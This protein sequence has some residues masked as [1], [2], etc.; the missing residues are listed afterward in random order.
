[1]TDR[2]MMVI[3]NNSLS[4]PRIVKR[5]VQT[6]IAMAIT[7][8]VVL[9]LVMGNSILLPR[10]GWVQGIDTW[11][12]FIRRSDILGT[13]ALTAFVTMMYLSWERSRGKR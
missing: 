4:V 8:A 12:A 3:G 2:T 6:G 5:T 10:G 11:L 7:A 13:M 1:M 9:A